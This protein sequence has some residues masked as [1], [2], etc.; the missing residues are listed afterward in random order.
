MHSQFLSL[1][2]FD[3]ILSEIFYQHLGPPPPIREMLFNVQSS[4]KS[5]ETDQ[6]IGSVGDPQPFTGQINYRAIEP[7]YD[8]TYTHTE[9]AD[10][11][12]FERKLL[13]DM[14]YGPIFGSAQDFGLAFGRKREKD[15][16]SVFNNAFTAGAT[17][18][19]DAVALCSSSHPRGESDTGNTIDN[20]LTLALS[21]ANVQSA[22]QA[23][24]DFVD[25][26]GNLVTVRPDILLVPSELEQ[27]AYELT[28]SVLD[29]ENANNA[30]NWI[31]KTLKAVV[32]D[33][34]TD[35]NAWFLIDSRLAKRYLKWYD[36]VLP[37]FKTTVDFDTYE[38]KVAAYMRYSFG[39]SEWRW[40]I[41]SNP[42]QGG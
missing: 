19:Y 37:E 14:Q 10:G 7:D 13:D 34:L 31:S 25:D 4:S 8:V 42:S 41:G 27:T 2:D 16:A 32:W 35:A 21:K 17:A 26:K 3:P 1:T 29:P 11:L 6:R 36:R 39:W 20:S 30:A 28:V 33:Y 38:L 15:A 23:M 22:R 40:I 12:K 24:R 18:G 5:K 9:W